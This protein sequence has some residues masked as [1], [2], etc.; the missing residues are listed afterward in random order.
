MS[1]L[2]AVIITYNEE[3]NIRRCLQSIKDLA[4]E[5]I[6]VDSFSNDN[7]EKICSEYPVK[8]IKREFEGYIEQKRYAL[9]LAN[10]E[11]V[12]SLDADEALSDELKNS[13]GEAKQ[14][15]TCDGYSMNRLTNYCGKWIKHCNWYPDRKLRLFNK[16][17]G[18][19]GGE[20]PHD[21]VILQPGAKTCHLK[22]DILHYSYYTLDDH[23]KQIENFTNIS[24]KSLFEKGKKSNWIKLYL[25][26]LA[27]FIRD[28]FLNLGFLDGKAGFKICWLSAG[29]T[30]KKYRKLQILTKE[31]GSENG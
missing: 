3:K 29:A 25:A 1:L 19:W 9:G 22:G 14:N 15:F 20:N 4:D 30:Y 2:S 5:I 13:I 26:P 24:S 27:K 23:L 12:L 7:T 10:N 16:N 17:R 28:Y 11:F 31:S 8:F 21:K 6:I 18:K